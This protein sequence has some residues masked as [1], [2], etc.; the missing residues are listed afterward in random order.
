MED[1]DVTE[2]IFKST[3]KAGFEGVTWMDAGSR[4]FYTVK[5]CIQP[6]SPASMKDPRQC[7]L[8]Q[9]REQR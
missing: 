2:P 3:R 4:S 9:T 8:P 1:E 7:R 6:S 5:R